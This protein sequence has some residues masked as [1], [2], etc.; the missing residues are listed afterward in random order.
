MSAQTITPSRH[1]K[2]EWARCAQALY[3][4]PDQ[5]ASQPD[6]AAMDLAR[7]DGIAHYYR[8]W[9]VFGAQS[10]LSEEAQS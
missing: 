4:I 3:W 2:I 8:Q 9:L 6:G 5:N 1:E 10:M 7:F